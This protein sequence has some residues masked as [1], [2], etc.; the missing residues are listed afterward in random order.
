MMS[1]GCVSP[2]SAPFPLNSSPGPQ[3]A[4]SAPSVNPATPGAPTPS[5]ATATAA[6][7]GNH[8]RETGEDSL[9]CCQ[10]AGCL[11]GQSCQLGVAGR[12]E[13]AQIPKTETAQSKQIEIDYLKIRDNMQAWVATTP[14]STVGT[15]PLFTPLLDMDAQIRT[16]EAS[17]YDVRAERAMRDI[18]DSVYR[19]QINL[20]A[21]KN[22]AQARVTQAATLARDRYLNAIT[23]S[24]DEVQ[25]AIS[26]AK[27]DQ[28]RLLKVWDADKRARQEAIDRYGLDE[29]LWQLPSQ[30]QTSLEALQ[31]SL[32]TDQTKTA[33]HNQNEW[34]QSGTVRIRLGPLS[35]ASCV[36]DD[37]GASVSYLVIPVELENQGDHSVSFGPSAF[38]V[39][40]WYKNQFAPATPPVNSTSRD[41][42]NYYNDNAGLLEQKLLPGSHA[43]GQVWVDVRGSYSAYPWEI[44]ADMP[45]GEQIA[46]RIAS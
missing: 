30:E 37:N 12:Y 15:E 10:D 36:R 38:T 45:N 17:G 22:S 11:E 24:L 42:V 23:L 19:D 14:T 2:M 40:D 18:L 8:L 6:V 20:E 46:W 28:T 43:K 21:R 31:S 35:G 32:K 33:P 16:L 41:C 44:Y 39:R 4:P 3:A 27:I 25:S 1:A 29:N 13:C 5:N 9:T 26:D 7:C 34:V